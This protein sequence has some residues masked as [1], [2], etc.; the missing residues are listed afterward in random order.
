MIYTKPNGTVIEINNSKASIEKA[1]ELGWKEGK[2][3]VK[4]VKKE[5]K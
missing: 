1:K 3:K 5:A 4:A 2:P